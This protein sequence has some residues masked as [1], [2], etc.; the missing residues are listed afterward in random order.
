[1]SAQGIRKAI[2]EYFL[3]ILGTTL[4]AIAITVFFDAYGMVIGGISGIAIILKELT[5]G[6]IDGGI[7]IW[8]T[9]LV[10]NVP[11]FLLALLIK[12]KDFG[13][14]SLFA[15]MYLSFALY[16]TQFIPA[17]EINITLSSIFGGVVAGLGL[18]LV[19]SVFATTGG[20]DLAAS[21]IQHFVKYL[22]V[23]KIMMILDGLII[24]G[25]FFVFGIEKTLYA[26]ISI[27]IT[28]KVIDAILEG[29]NFAKATFIITEHDEEVA[30]SLLSK[31]ERGVTGLHGQGMYTGNQK[32]VLLCVVPL[33]QIGKLK[34][35]VKEIDSNA[36]VIVADVR[37]VLGEGFIE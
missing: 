4:L 31:L 2:K 30:K 10:L 16:I 6:V 11:L 37:E 20:T 32:T 15:T 9:N 14:K 3:I 17:I 5:L 24:A 1:M 33:R 12:G 36:F 7:P 28:V 8:L 19:F 18:G 23:A 25:G 27:F 35:I 22:S 34:E 13:W 21:I 29:I 26:L